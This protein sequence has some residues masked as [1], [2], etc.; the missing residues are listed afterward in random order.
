MFSV[1]KIFISENIR[2]QFYI[3]PTGNLYKTTAIDVFY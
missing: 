3:K 2:K 1:E